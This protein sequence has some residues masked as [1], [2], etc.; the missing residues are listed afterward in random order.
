MSSGADVNGAI[1]VRG[2][3]S[4]ERFEQTYPVNI[5]ATTG[6]GNA[7][8]PRLYAAAK[9]AELEETG[10]DAQKPA[11]I[12]L[13]RRFSVASRF[14]SL[15]VLESEAMF[16]AFGLDRGGI[17]SAFTG[18]EQAE[19]VSASAE[20]EEPDAA[21]EGAEEKGDAL[22][23]G[24]WP[25][26]Q[27]QGGGGSGWPDVAP[28]AKAESRTSAGAARRRPPSRSAG[29]TSRS[30]PSRARSTPTCRRP[31]RRRRPPRPRS[32]SRRPRRT[33]A[34]GDRPTTTSSPPRSGRARGRG[35]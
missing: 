6:A 34:P 4:G 35:G 10:G 3:V 24:A 16:K 18:E 19:R 22:G 26:G 32:R 31:R 30:I 1:R 5:V 29:S 33:I 11:I 17:A 2:R 9:I 13:S 20:G 25:V 8:V 15:L 23:A 21:D 7:F 28:A 12:E 14:T 27:R